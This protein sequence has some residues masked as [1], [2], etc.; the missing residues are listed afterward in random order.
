MIN[1]SSSG[2]VFSGYVFSVSEHIKTFEMQYWDGVTRYSI[3][4]ALGLILVT[5]P[6]D[7]A[8][9]QTW[10]QARRAKFVSAYL[11]LHLNHRVQKSQRKNRIASRPNEPSVL[12]TV[13]ITELEKTQCFSGIQVQ[14]PNICSLCDDITRGRQRLAVRSSKALDRQESIKWIAVL[15]FRAFYFR[16]YSS[17]IK[18]TFPEF[19]FDN[20]RS[21]NYQK[22]DKNEFEV[23]YFI[24]I[25]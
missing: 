1:S 8:T 3:T 15:C 7:S 19:H 18:W 20:Y 9:S 5:W 22:R 11:G 12:G 25:W 16:Y 13:R 6:Q 14:V 21:Q 23:V 4:I 17:R 2:Y 24:M 10:P